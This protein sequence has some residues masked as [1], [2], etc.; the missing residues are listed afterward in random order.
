MSKYY[1]FTL[2][3]LALL[4]WSCVTKRTS[5]IV[6]FDYDQVKNQTNYSVL[7]LGSVAIPGKWTKT[8]YNSVSN[9]Q[10]FTNDESVEIAVAINRYDRYEF[11]EEGKAKGFAF[12]KA[13]YEWDSK[14]LV[15]QHGLKRSLLENDSLNNYLIYRIFSPTGAGK[16]DTYFLIGERRGNT[17]NLSISYTDK[18]SE[19]KKIEFLRDLFVKR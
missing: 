6:S 15:D 9:Q 17:N 2:S 18:W 4:L 11:N 7:P 12:V 10:F 16:I 8:R 19:S 14:Y 1:F 13:Y 5:T 3:I